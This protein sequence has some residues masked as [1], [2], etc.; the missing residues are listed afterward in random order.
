[1]FLFRFAQ[2]LSQLLGMPLYSPNG[3]SILTTDDVRDP[4]RWRTCA[5]VIGPLRRYEDLP[6]IDKSQIILHLRDP[7]DALTSFYF[8]MAQSHQ[9]NETVSK[10]RQLAR[11]TSIDQFTFQPSMDGIAPAEAFLDVYR[12]YCDKLL[13]RDNVVHVS[14]EQMLFDFH[15]WVQSIIEP[16]PLS[17][18]SS[19]IDRLCM[20]YKDEFTEKPENDL[21]HKRQLKPG[22]HLRKMNIETVSRLNLMFR[23]VLSQLRYPVDAEAGTR[24][25]H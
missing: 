18:K 21:D 14:Y 8:S 7:R 19:V 15:G 10:L 20:R 5:G 3:G 11:S 22:D 2:D 4:D 25:R 6:I 16:L 17:D 13:H 1:M 24:Q 12:T 9:P 23:D